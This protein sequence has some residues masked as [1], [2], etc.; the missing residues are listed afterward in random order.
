M[1]DKIRL[2][3]SERC[4]LCNDRIKALEDD[5]VSTEVRKNF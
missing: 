2:I 3:V 4:Y 1:L 5:L